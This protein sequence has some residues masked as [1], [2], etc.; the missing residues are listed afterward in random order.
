[1][2]KTDPLN[3]LEFLKSHNVFC[4]VPQTLLKTVVRGTTRVRMRRGAMLFKEGSRGNS[5]F[6]IESGKLAIEKDGVKIVT[7]IAGE[8]VGEFSV[9]DQSPRS[10][11]VTAETDCVLLKV[12]REAFQ[13]LLRSDPGLAGRIHSML[14]SKLRQDLSQQVDSS[15]RTDR[16]VQQ[17]QMQRDAAFDALNH[18]PLGVVLIDGD[19]RSIFVNIRGKEIMNRK[20]GLFI[21][22]N[23]LLHATQ[24]SEDLDLRNFIREA[25]QT[26]AGWGSQ[27][28]GAMTVSRRSG[29]RPFSIIVTPLQAKDLAIRNRIPAAAVFLSD[30]ES[31]LDAADQILNR[32]YSLSPAEARLALLL[33]QGKRLDE[34]ARELH[35]APSTVRSHLK[36][37]FL[38]TGT[39]RQSDLIRLILSGPAIVKA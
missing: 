5:L 4:K 23:G 19:Q 20:D 22:S 10:G 27:P 30:P 6:I 18:L 35:I 39:N 28:G 26:G 13:K 9:L 37:I 24:H 14:T 34:A 33:L 38:K 29:N 25:A 31:G 7:R 2:A 15:R 12:K 8:L 11:T 21:D 3:I 17:L 36:R 16:I 1:M 32:L